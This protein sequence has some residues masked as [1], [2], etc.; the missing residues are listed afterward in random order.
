VLGYKVTNVSLV[1]DLETGELQFVSV[2]IDN[3]GW[4]EWKILSK[5][6]KKRLVEEGFSDIAGRVALVYR[7]ALQTRK[8]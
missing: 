7:K 4:M 2:Y 8:G 6:V 3:C 5:F 1:E